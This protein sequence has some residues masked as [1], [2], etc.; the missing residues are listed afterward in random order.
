M[1]SE[2]QQQSPGN[3]EQENVRIETTP[4]ADVPE[5]MGHYSYGIFKRPLRFD[6][7]AIIFALLV[8]AGGITGYVNKNSS[9]SLIAGTIFAIL[10]GI[11][12]Y[13]EGA[14]R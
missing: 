6:P 1:S 8:F 9:A 12:I 3:Q 13:I 11:T 10:L 4:Q 14:R 5:T 2:A 7:L